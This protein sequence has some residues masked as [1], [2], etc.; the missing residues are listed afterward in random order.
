VISRA[1]YLVIV[2][3]GL[4]TSNALAGL[5]LETETARPPGPGI[6]E[7][8]SAYERQVSSSGGEAAVPLAFE[9][10]LGKRGE[11]LVEPV[12]YTW[13]GP[14]HGPNA[15]GL[16]DLEVTGLYLLLEEQG[17]R[18][19]IALAAE[20]KLPTARNRLIGSGKA[21]G[22]FYLIGSKRLGRYEAHAN[23]DYA[24]IGHPAGIRVN[25][26]FG[27]AFALE[28]HVRPRLD[29]VGEVYGSTAALAEAADAPRSAGESVVTPEIGEGEVVA[30]L[31][32]RYRLT[33]RV[34]C[35]FGVSRDNTGAFLLQPGLT[36]IL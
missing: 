29:L 33:P 26:V 36:A 5:P 23:L 20:P 27:G 14:K 8:E 13:I 9:V 34:R 28:Y 19:A 32:A 35:S 12:P 18:P 1:A 24:M 22:T 15:H 31:G 4:A 11:L 25:N 16:G 6:V 3:L 2:G 21:D 7:V 17:T 30:M 10:G